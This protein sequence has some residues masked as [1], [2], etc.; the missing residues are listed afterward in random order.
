MKY[1]LYCLCCTLH[2]CILFIY[3]FIFEFYFIWFFLEQ[4]LISHPFYTH[5]CIHVN[6]NLPIHH[7]TTPT[8]PRLSPLGV[9]MFVL[10]VCVSISALQTGSS[11]PFFQVPHICV[12]IRYLKN[13]VFKCTEFVVSQ[14]ARLRLLFFCCFF[15]KEL[16]HFNSG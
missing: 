4:V 1:W 12:T 5:Q 14:C 15:Y 8:P 11:V 7:T 9:R 13:Y 16:K 6:P 3:L 2:P 10:Y